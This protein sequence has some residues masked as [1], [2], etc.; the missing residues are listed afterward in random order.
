ME[1]IATAEFTGNKPNSF[2]WDWGDGS[3]VEETADP[4]KTHTYTL[5]PGVETEFT[6]TV[7]YDDGDGC[8]GSKS[9]KIG[10]RGPCP[11]IL[12]HLCTQKDLDDQFTEVEITLKLD[13]DKGAP[14]G[15]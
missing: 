3:A 5:T 8:S 9:E 15:I 13:P 12:Q 14:S 6:V 10:G 4:Q 2:K 7:S 1:V 11:A